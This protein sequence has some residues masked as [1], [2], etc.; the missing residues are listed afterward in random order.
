MDPVSEVMRS[1]LRQRAAALKW[2]DG[3]LSV[4]SCHM[5]WHLVFDGVSDG[6]VGIGLEVVGAAARVVQAGRTAAEHAAPR[7]RVVSMT[8]ASTSNALRPKS[9]ICPPWVCPASVRWKHDESMTISSGRRA[10]KR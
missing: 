1:T 3:H 5:I 6:S 10:G 2:R 4:Y 9:P 8:G 7:Q